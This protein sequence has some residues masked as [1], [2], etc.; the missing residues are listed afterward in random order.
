MDTQH[1]LTPP[2]PQSAPQHYFQPPPLVIL[3]NPIPHQG[4]INTQ[5]EINSTPP[6]MGKYHNPSPNQPENLV[7]RN[8]LHTSEGEIILQTRS[9]KYDIP[10]KY[11]PNTSKT[12][13]ATT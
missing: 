6:P 5:Q 1:P 10:P 9:H 4:M 12:T 8:I 11:T 2:A 3:Q 7:D 13:P